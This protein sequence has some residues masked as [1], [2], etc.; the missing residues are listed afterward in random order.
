MKKE[1]RTPLFLLPLEDV[2]AA[3]VHEEGNNTYD[4]NAEDDVGPHKGTVVLD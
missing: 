4:N 3:E 1:G 2:V